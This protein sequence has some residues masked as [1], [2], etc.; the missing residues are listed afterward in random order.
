MLKK[1]H[2][3]TEQRIWELKLNLVEKI[4][5]IIENK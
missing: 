1:L 3:E 4:V 5:K 2:Q